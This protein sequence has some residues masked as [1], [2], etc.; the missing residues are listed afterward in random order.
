MLQGIIFG[1]LPGATCG[2]SIAIVI[3]VIV[4]M[5]CPV[6]HKGGY[7]VPDW[8]M[9]PILCVILVG[10][11]VA[12][13]RALPSSC[14]WRSSKR[15]LFLKLLLWGTIGGLLGTLANLSQGFEGYFCSN[16]KVIR[17]AVGGLVFGSTAA[18]LWR[19][20][21]EMLIR[22]N[23]QHPVDPDR[24]SV[25]YV[26][27]RSWRRMGE[28]VLVVFAG[29]LISAWI[30]T[31]VLLRTS[32]STGPHFTASINCLLP[33]FPTVVVEPRIGMEPKC[34]GVFTFVG[35]ALVSEC[36]YDSN[37]RF[38]SGTTYGP[39]APDSFP[40][41]DRGDGTLAPA[42]KPN[43][44]GWSDGETIEASCEGQLA[45]RHRRAGLEALLQIIVPILAGFAT[46]SVF[47]TL[48]WKRLSRITAS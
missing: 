32:F 43:I 4:V 41:E 22:A 42:E 19:A 26:D 7:E 17:C 29:V 39:L 8:C 25:R 28:P 24:G 31:Y 14:A 33:I 1:M 48:R 9:V 10:P 20:T 27:R 13:T 11:G 5:V 44:T 47:R 38:V 12:A 6:G 3:G 2:A 30:T 23:G 15:Q 45:F 34:R 16:E 40:P 36:W 18:L 37:N 46:Y 21:V 35:V